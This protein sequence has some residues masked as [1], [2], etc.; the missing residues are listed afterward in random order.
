MSDEE[1]KLDPLPHAGDRQYDE[2]TLDEALKLLQSW[3]RTVTFI[4][5][6]S[7]NHPEYATAHPEYWHGY[8]ICLRR[9][10]EMLGSMAESRHSRESFG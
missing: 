6:E 3:H 10:M 4:S 5:R 9:V 8:Q 7:N 1:L 2:L